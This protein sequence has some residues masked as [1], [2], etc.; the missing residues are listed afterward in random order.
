MHHRKA[1][2]MM[3]KPSVTDSSFD[4][5]PEN[6]SRWVRGRIETWSDGKT[7]S[8]ALLVFKYLR[9]YRSGIRSDGAPWGPQGKPCCLA[10]SSV[11]VWYPPEASR[12]SLVQGKIIKKFRIV[13]TLFDTDFLE[14]KNNQK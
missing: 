12:I 11:A 2:M 6:I 4:R 10:V 7:V 3:Q 5:V 14:N 8:D 13:W 9:I 1:A